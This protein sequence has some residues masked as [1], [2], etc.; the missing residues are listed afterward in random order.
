VF[1]SRRASDLAPAQLVP[2]ILL[3]RFAILARDEE[4][5]LVAQERSKEKIGD[6]DDP[7]FDALIELAPEYE[8]ALLRHHTGEVEGDRKLLRRRAELHYE[9]HM[10]ED[11]ALDGSLLL[12]RHRDNLGARYLAA[13]VLSRFR[14]HDP[15]KL[16]SGYTNTESA[17]EARMDV[18]LVLGETPVPQGDRGKTLTDTRY[19]PEKVASAAP[20]WPL[21][22]K[23]FEHEPPPRF[24]VNKIL[25]NIPGVLGWS[26][27]SR[28]ISILRTEKSTGDLPPPIGVLFRTGPTVLSTARGAAV[29]RLDGGGLP[30]YA[31]VTIDNGQDVIGLGLTP[32][33]ARDAVLY[34]IGALEIPSAE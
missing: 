30:M 7:S 8:L 27:P 5:V 15:E 12:D 21:G 14:H 20:T 2:A 11:A 10:F 9:R 32:Q 31:G 18:Q 13:G 1:A 6:S 23:V 33:A 26:D 28:Q 16:L 4:Q 17:R 22:M 29:V 25:S 19:R 3:Q 34:G 24:Q